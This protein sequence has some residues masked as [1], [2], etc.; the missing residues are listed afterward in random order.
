MFVRK[1]L[2]GN[3]FPSIFMNEGIL[4]A[5]GQ[6]QWP[7]RPFNHMCQVYNQNFVI[8]NLKIIH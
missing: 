7:V 4:T 5:Q 1:N 3:I 8:M 6:L 2:D